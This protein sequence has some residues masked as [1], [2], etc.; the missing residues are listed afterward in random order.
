MD[1]TIALDTAWLNL[2]IRDDGRGLP[3]QT[4][5]LGNGLIN[6]K[7]RVESF[8]G[9]IVVAGG[10]GTLLTARIPAGEVETVSGDRS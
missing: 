2:N 7:I 5:S 8:G 6:M 4:D 9:E 3:A 10:Q 1:V